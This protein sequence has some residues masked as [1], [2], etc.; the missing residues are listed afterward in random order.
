MTK[1]ENEAQYMTS[2]RHMMY[3]MGAHCKMFMLVDGEWLATQNS[4]VDIRKMCTFRKRDGQ[5]VDVSKK[6]TTVRKR[7]EKA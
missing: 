4:F 7:Y 3:K 2:D 5:W 1:Q 6:A